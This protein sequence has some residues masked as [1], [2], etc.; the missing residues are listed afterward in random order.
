M[1]ARRTFDNIYIYIDINIYGF[2]KRYIYI[3]I[4]LHLSRYHYTHKLLKNIYI[5]LNTMHKYMYLLCI[6]S[7]MHMA[8]SSTW[9]VCV[10]PW[11]VAVQYLGS[12][13]IART[14]TGRQQCTHSART[15]HAQCTLT[16]HGLEMLQIAQK[17]VS[18][19]QNKEK[20]GFM[21]FYLI[22]CHFN[23]LR[24]IYTISGACTVACTAACTVRALCV[25]CQ[26]THI[27]V[28]YSAPSSASS[29]SSLLHLP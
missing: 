4:Y 8:A 17:K 13:A 18:R 5:Y 15:V 11:Q 23:S 24:A 26:N 1:C 9:G 28:L 21:I 20:A 3:Y 16:V 2:K 7:Y 27:C 10:A 6:Y 22:A 29:C 25:H 14:R 12:P 19:H